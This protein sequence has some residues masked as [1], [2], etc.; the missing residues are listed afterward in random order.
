MQEK[1]KEE[2]MKGT[3]EECEENSRT[4]SNLGRHCKI[5]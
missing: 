5:D 4:G 1:N 2:H 3:K